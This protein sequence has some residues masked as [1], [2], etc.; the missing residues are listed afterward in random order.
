MSTY[1]KCLIIGS[2]SS[3]HIRPWFLHGF[4]V[5]IGFYESKCLFEGDERINFESDSDICRLVCVSCLNAGLW[6]SADV[7]D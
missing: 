1:S 6:S 2:N 5:I 4:Y 7:I 3:K